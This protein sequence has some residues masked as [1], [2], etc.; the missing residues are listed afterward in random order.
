VPLLGLLSGPVRLGISVAV[1]L[2]VGCIVW[3]VVDKW[4]A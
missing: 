4:T 3:Y 1:A 2:T